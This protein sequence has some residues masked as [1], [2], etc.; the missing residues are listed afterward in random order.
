MQLYQPPSTNR[1]LNLQ[2]GQDW[3]T[4]TK[5]HENYQ[6]FTALSDTVAE[7][8][9]DRFDWSESRGMKYGQWYQH[10]YMSILGIKT[11][12]NLLD[13]GRV[14]SIIV[15]SGSIINSIPLRKWIRFC[16]FTLY[17]L[18]GFCTRLD[19]YADDDTGAIASVR[20]KIL[21]HCQ[22]DKPELV[23]GFRKYETVNS[24]SL[25]KLKCQTLYLGSRESDRYIRIYDKLK[26]E[27]GVKNEENGVK[28]NASKEERREENGVKE[29]ANRE[30]RREE[31]HYKRR[32]E[33]RE[34]KR[35]RK[36]NRSFGSRDEIVSNAS[37]QSQIKYQRWEMEVKSN[38]AN[39]IFQLICKC[40]HDWCKQDDILDI[41]QVF[42]RDIIFSGYQFFSERLNAS[43]ERKNVICDWWEQFLESIKH[44]QFKVPIVRPVRTIERVAGFLQRQCATSL[45]L[46]RKY[47]GIRYLD[48]LNSLYQSGEDRL[49]RAQ[50]LMLELN[51]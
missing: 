18:G 47:L 1:G 48:W 29:N 43:L 24:G 38:Q 34:K 14:E 22:L 42:M 5:T 19:I 6:Q 41:L 26:D 33:R 20:D 51:I 46:M 3:F 17:P 36:P 50:L 2:I 9:G 45:A 49:S 32:A 11:G 13:D 12:Y 21:T 4:W 10:G 31:F 44:S 39:S 37:S 35:R 8:F 28:E 16:S 7:E 40:Y 25:G 15:I 30:E 23:S 27:N